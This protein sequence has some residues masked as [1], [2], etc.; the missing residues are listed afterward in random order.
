MI[1]EQ[2]QD[3]DKAAEMLAALISRLDGLTDSDRYY[4]SVCLAKKRLTDY[5]DG[6]LSVFNHRHD[7]PRQEHAAENPPKSEPAL[8]ETTPPLESK[9][10]EPLTIGTC[11]T[12]DRRQFA[13]DS[14]DDSTQKVSLQDVIFEDGT[15]RDSPSS[16]RNP[17]N[18]SAL[19]WS[20][21]TWRRKPQHRRRT[22]RLRHSPRRKRKSGTHLPMHNHVFQ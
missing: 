17:S 22:N 18:M 4:D 13:V 7:T 6:T 2:L 8:Q 1:E 12:I 10:P 16:E 21:R 11:L 14:V 9:A 15:G 3:K 5:V 20:N 19:T